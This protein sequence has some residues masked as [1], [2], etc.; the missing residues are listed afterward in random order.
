MVPEMQIVI[1]VTAIGKRTP[2]ISTIF[3]LIRAVMII[4]TTVA[5]RMFES[6]N[7]SKAARM[8]AGLT[9]MDPPWGNVISKNSAVQTKAAKKMN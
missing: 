9:E 1:E 5:T 3:R 8:I 4:P 7:R 6:G 2:P